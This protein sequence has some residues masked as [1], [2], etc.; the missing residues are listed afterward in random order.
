MESLTQITLIITLLRAIWENDGFYRW[1][2]YRK[3][4]KTEN[5]YKN[6]IS[7]WKWNEIYTWK[8]HSVKSKKFE[9]K[10]ICLNEKVEMNFEFAFC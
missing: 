9:I 1:L 5:K 7:I 3:L 6:I 10:L 8:Y 4:S 2:V